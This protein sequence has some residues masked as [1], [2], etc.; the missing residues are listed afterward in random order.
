MAK[1]KFACI[2]DRCS[3]RGP[4]YEFFPHCT[5]CDL[6][7]CESCLPDADPETGKGV[8]LKCKLCADCGMPKEFE[9]LSDER[10]L[11]CERAYREKMAE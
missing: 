5:V 4:E 2:C 11:L 6:E 3:T 8:C 10:C 1:V 9:R 7:L